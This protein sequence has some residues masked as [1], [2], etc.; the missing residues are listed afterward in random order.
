VQAPAL[1]IP[2]GVQSVHDRHV[3]TV[4]EYRELSDRHCH[5]IPIAASTRKSPAPALRANPA[6]SLEQRRIVLPYKNPDDF[7]RVVEGLRKAGL[8]E[9]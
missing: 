4:S 1:N 8:P 6:Y 7:E 3:V 2:F 9:Q 5:Q